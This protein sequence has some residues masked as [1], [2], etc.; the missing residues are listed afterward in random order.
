MQS[1]ALLSLDR[2]DG[3]FQA[4]ALGCNGIGIGH[5]LLAKTGLQGLARRL[6]DPSPDLRIGTLGSLQG[7]SD[8]RL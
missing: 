2:P 8:G 4:L 7:V 5:V 6:V 1:L 3:H